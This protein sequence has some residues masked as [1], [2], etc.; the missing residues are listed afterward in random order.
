MSDKLRLF[1]ESIARLNYD[2]EGLDN[3]E[4]FLMENDDAVDTMNS[5]IL[6]AR[7][8]VGVDP[9]PSQPDYANVVQSHP[10]DRP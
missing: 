4:E 2:G 10:G 8:L 7:E 6:R 5:L 1:V 3:G 9:P